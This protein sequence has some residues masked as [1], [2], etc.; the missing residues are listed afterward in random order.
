M[1]VKPFK[2]PLCCQSYRDGCMSV[3][4]LLEW[5][6]YTGFLHSSL[7]LC[8]QHV[9]FQ[10]VFIFSFEF[11]I[12]AHLIQCVSVCVCVCV[13]VCMCAHMLHSSDHQAVCHELCH[14]SHGP[15]A[16]RVSHIVM[17]PCQC[18]NCWNGFG[19]LLK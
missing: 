11:G 17:V 18:Q 1:C 12:S 5:F 3:L 4:K 10:Q 7:R 14:P 9:I 19:T 2:C 15:S 8:Q 6:Q 13:C 16:S